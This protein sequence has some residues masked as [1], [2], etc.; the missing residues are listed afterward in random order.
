MWISGFIVW[1]ME[2]LENVDFDWIFSIGWIKN[3]GIKLRTKDSLCDVGIKWKK[4]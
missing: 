3:E 4:C 1:E 2:S